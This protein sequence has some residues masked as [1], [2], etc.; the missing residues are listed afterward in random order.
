MTFCHVATLDYRMDKVRSRHFVLP[1][2]QSKQKKF[3]MQNFFSKYF[4]EK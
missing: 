1:T 3:D 4:R 2:P